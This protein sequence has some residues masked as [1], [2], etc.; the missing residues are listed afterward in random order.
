MPFP[1]WGRFGLVGLGH[2][3]LGLITLRHLLVPDFLLLS[4]KSVTFECVNN[5]S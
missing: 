4:L 5:W 1:V 2:I 3:S